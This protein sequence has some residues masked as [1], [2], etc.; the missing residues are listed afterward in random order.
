M[1]DCTQWLPDELWDMVLSG[2]DS[3]DVAFICPTQRLLLRLVCARW[4]LLVENPSSVWRHGHLLRAWYAL[5]GGRR[6]EHRT[7]F[8]SG[9]L[10]T[11]TGALVFVCHGGDHK[12]PLIPISRHGIATPYGTRD[13]RDDTMEI[14]RP[15]DRA[16]LDKSTETHDA[17][18]WVSHCN[19]RILFYVDAVCVKGSC[20]PSAKLASSTRDVCTSIASGPAPFDAG[21]RHRVECTTRALV[22]LNRFEDALCLLWHNIPRSVNCFKAPDAA[23]RVLCDVLFRAGPRRLYWLCVGLSVIAYMFEDHP[24]LMADG[25]M[26]SC[27]WHAL[28]RTSDVRCI[29]ALGEILCATDERRPIPDAHLPFALDDV[30]HTV[31][32]ITGRNDASL[33]TTH[34]RMSRSLLRTRLFFFNAGSRVIGGVGED[35][36]GWDNAVVDGPDAL[37]VIA[38][39]GC[40]RYMVE[41]SIR[42]AIVHADDLA[43]ADRIVGMVRTRQPAFCLDAKHFVPHVLATSPRLDIVV[44]W[45]VCQGGD[46]PMTTLLRDCVDAVMDR[47]SARIHDK[48]AQ[49]AA[50]L[51]EAIAHAW[52]AQLSA[53]CDIVRDALAQMLRHGHWQAASLAV[54]A[55][56]PLYPWNSSVPLFATKKPDGRSCDEPVDGIHSDS[57]MGSKESIWNRLC[58]G[59]LLV[60]AADPDDGRAPKCKPG[61]AYALAR[62]ADFCDPTHHADP[63]AAAA[64]RLLCGKPT[65]IE[66][67]SG[68]RAVLSL[69]RRGLLH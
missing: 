23:L 59:Q 53:D 27:L 26:M 29:D 38:L 13:H 6:R 57:P 12:A 39:Y 58:S 9:R 34:A 55:I 14:C 22:A 18:H 54:A 28:N 30:L 62:L 1:V 36:S 2:A 33:F 50:H 65:P 15:F 44:R 4:R 67:D 45:F 11:P 63:H 43:L 46:V 49:R 48:D 56:V 3:R 5:P 35:S 32:R 42:A 68:E 41:R 31:C 8:F 64:W 7:L 25:L 60:R 24:M 10:A 21:K 37:S 20:E 17:Q 19:T 40:K 69:A 52:P 51:L 47:D 16:P 66:G 61:R